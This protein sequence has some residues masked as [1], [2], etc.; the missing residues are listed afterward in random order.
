M[1]VLVPA[2]NE[3]GKILPT[4]ADIRAQLAAGDRLLVVA[5][6]CDDDT[7]PVARSPAQ[8]SSIARPYRVGKGYA[9]D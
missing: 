2:H 6:N 3:S 1:A 7:A 8:K 5:D 9:L 4:L